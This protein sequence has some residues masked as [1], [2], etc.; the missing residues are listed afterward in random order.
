MSSIK[1]TFSQNRIFRWLP[2][3]LMMLAIF[4]YSAG[5]ALDIPQSGLRLFVN[6]SGHVI[7]YAMLAL[8]YWRGFNFNAN[9]RWGAWLLAV[10]YAMTDEFH[11]S[12]VPGRHSSLFD[13]LVYDNLGACIGMLLA[14]L[15]LKQKQPVRHRRVVENESITAKRQ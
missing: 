2:A 12:F 3:A 4:L 9:K 7:G 8:S 10:L 14:G 6:K 13:V 5:P 15:S 1:L 11:Q